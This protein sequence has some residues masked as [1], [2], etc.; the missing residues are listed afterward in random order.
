MRR[1]RRHHRELAADHGVAL[2][3]GELP[4]H[5]AL[6]HEDELDAVVAVPGMRAGARQVVVAELLDQLE[7]DLPAPAAQQMR[8]CRVPAAAASHPLIPVMVSPAMMKRWA[9]RKTRSTG[10]ITID[11]AAITTARL[12]LPMNP[13]K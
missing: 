5:L 4:L 2:A 9:S 11:I 8:L 3:V 13:R 7:A 1:A 10:V 12:P 6:G